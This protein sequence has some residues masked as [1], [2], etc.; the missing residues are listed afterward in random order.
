MKLADSDLKCNIYE[1]I[2]IYC[3]CPLNNKP[4]TNLSIKS[5]VIQPKVQNAILMYVNFDVIELEMVNIKQLIPM[6]KSR[7]D[8]QYDVY[9]EYSA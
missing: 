3:D 7:R 9:L 8:A 5:E 6:I 2:Y 4:T 1:H